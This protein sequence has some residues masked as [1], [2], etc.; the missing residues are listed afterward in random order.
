MRTC[1]RFASR[2]FFIAWSSERNDFTITNK[3][4]AEIVRKFENVSCHVLQ[5]YGQFFPPNGEEI[6]HSLAAVFCESYARIIKQIAKRPPSRIRGFTNGRACVPHT[7]I[8]KY[9]HILRSCIVLRASTFRAY[10]PCSNVPNQEAVNISAVIVKRLRRA[11]F[12]CIR[13]KL[14]A[15]TRR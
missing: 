3:G 1:K 5:G 9:K 8:C 12:P 15:R 7:V 4:S 11:S 14:Y 2:C 10:Y 13:C 6:L